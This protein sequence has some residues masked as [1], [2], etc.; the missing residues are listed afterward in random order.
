MWPLVKWDWEY[1][2]ESSNSAKLLHDVAQCDSLKVWPI[3]D[4][5]RRGDCFTKGCFH[6]KRSSAGSQKAQKTCEC[7]LLPS[8]L[9]CLGSCKNPLWCCGWAKKN[10][11]GR[12]SGMTGSNGILEWHTNDIPNVISGFGTG[13]SSGYGPTSD[14]KGLSRGGKRSC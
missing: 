4:T 8:Q 10:Q 7:L 14:L 6:L 5:S 9:C 1:F 3:N 13:S 11:R 2:L 12:I